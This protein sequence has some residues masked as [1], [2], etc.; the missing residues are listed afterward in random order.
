MKVAGIYGSPRVNGNSTQIAN[1]FLD[2]A[3]RLGAETS[4]FILNKLDFRGCQGCDVCKTRQAHCGL[5]DDLTEVLE[6]TRKADLLVLSTPVYYSDISSQLKAFIDRTYSFI[7]ADYLTNPNASRLEKGKKLLY[8]QSQEAGEDAYED[9]FSKYQIFFQFYGFEE[10]RVIKAF[11][12]G[13]SSS[14]E[15][16]EK[17]LD[18]AAEM[19]RIMCS[20]S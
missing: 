6:E 15:E 20:N 13:Q 16:R 4:C 1:R 7:D 9:L 11:G 14:S 3:E 2:E 8:I 5:N 17:Y 18:Q 10:Y 19:A 12:L